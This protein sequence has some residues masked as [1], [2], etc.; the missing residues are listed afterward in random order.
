VGGSEERDVARSRRQ[1][2]IERLNEKESELSGS[3]AGRPQLSEEELEAET[4][5]EGQ[6]NLSRMGFP[7]IFG[8]WRTAPS[9]W[10]SMSRLVFLG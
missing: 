1:R 8:P 6:L 5:K 3:R 4:E 7:Q 9:R 2:M 10:R